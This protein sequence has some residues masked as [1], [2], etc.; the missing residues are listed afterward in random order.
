MLF[1]RRL[2]DTVDIF[3]QAAQV[4]EALLDRTDNRRQRSSRRNLRRGLDLDDVVHASNT[5]PGQPAPNLP[6]FVKDWIERRS[7]SDEEVTSPPPFTWSSLSINT[8]SVFS[9]YPVNPML[10]DTT[11]DSLFWAR[12]FDMDFFELEDP[13]AIW[14]SSAA[15]DGGSVGGV[16]STGGSGSDDGGFGD[17]GMGM[18]SGAEGG[19]AVARTETETVTTGG[20]RTVLPGS[21]IWESVSGPI[22]SFDGGGGWARSSPLECL[23]LRSSSST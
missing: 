5:T 23:N 12:I 13:F 7:H 11:P 15:A 17:T 21:S 3:T 6:G 9:G 10:M 14:F 1:S 22:G 16:E 19:E 2:G 4:L 8:P 18:G 20:G